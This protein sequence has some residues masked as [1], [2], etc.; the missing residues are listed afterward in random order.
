MLCVPVREESMIEVST[1]R[2]LVKGLQ[3]MELNGFRSRQYNRAC[4][5]ILAALTHYHLTERNAP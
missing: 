3:M 5:D 4:V 2:Q 1:I